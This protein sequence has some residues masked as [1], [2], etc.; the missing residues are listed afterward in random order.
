[1]RHCQP[2]VKIVLQLTDEVDLVVEPRSLRGTHQQ[3]REDI[4]DRGA[5]TEDWLSRKVPR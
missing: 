5:P 2:G 1:M 4:R 3:E